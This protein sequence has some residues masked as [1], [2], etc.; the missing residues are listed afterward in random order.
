[1][2]RPLA[3]L[4]VVLLAG[5]PARPGRA[6]DP[7]Q[8]LTLALERVPLRQAIEQASREAG[9]PC[10]V[11]AGVPDFPISLNIRDVRLFQVLRLIAKQAGP[12]IGGTRS[13]ERYL[14]RLVPFAEQERDTVRWDRPDSR[15]AGRLTL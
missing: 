4:L 14:V 10:T 1:M 12:D 9:I 5:L 13:G 7:D 11:E 3:V 6:A 8:P 15:L 2:P